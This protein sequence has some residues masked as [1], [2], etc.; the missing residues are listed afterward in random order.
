MTHL[1]HLKSCIKFAAA[2]KAIPMKKVFVNV[3]A[4]VWAVKEIEN[5][6]NRPT[7]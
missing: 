2:E 1:D 4:L 6:N 7:T 5:A 3:E